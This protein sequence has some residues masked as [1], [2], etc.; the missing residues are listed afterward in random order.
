MPDNT[1]AI[2]DPVPAVPATASAAP[3]PASAAPAPAAS[4]PPSSAPAPAVPAPASPTPAPAARPGGIR[5]STRTAS[6]CILLFILLCGAYI[7]WHS[8]A[9]RKYRPRGLRPTALGFQWWNS[10]GPANNYPRPG[11]RPEP[12]AGAGVGPASSTS[13]LLPN[14][15][16]FYHK[17]LIYSRM[18]SLGFISAYRPLRPSAYPRLGFDSPYLVP[19]EVD[20]SIIVPKS[21]PGFPSMRPALATVPTRPTEPTGS[22][23]LAQSRGQPPPVFQPQSSSQTLAQI[24]PLAQPPA[25]ATAQPP[26][27]ASPADEKSIFT[28]LSPDLASS[29]CLTGDG[30]FLLAA[31]EAGNKIRIWEVKTGKKVNEITTPA[32][33]HLFCTGGNVYVANY[34]SGTI[35]VYAQQTWEQVNQLLVS[36]ANPYYISAPQGKYFDD[37]LLVSCGMKDNFEVH[38]VDIKKDS[39]RVVHSGRYELI[40]TLGYAG[41]TVLLQYANLSPQIECLAYSQFLKGETSRKKSL[42]TDTPGLQLLQQSEDSPFWFNGL[43]TVYN[44][45]SVYYGRQPAALAFNLTGNLVPDRKGLLAYL[46]T[47]K[48]IEAMRID[49]AFAP[50]ARAEANIGWRILGA[51]AGDRQAGLGLPRSPSPGLGM[52]GTQGAKWAMPGGQRQ[53]VHHD[54]AVYLFQICDGRIFRAVFPE[55]LAKAEVRPRLRPPPAPVQVATAGAE[56]PAKTIGGQPLRLALAP[57]GGGPGKFTLVKGP[58]GASLSPDGTLS[59]TP[60]PQDSGPVHFK[61][62]AEADGQVSFLRL[63]TDVVPASLAAKVGNDASKLNQIGQ[64]PLA[65]ENVLLRPLGDGSGV[66]LLEGR[67]LRIL[68]PDGI[69]ELQSHTFDLPYRKVADRKNYFVALGNNAV[70]LLDRKTFKVLRHYPIPCRE[71]YDLVLHPQ[72]P[73]AYVTLADADLNQG[74]SSANN[75]IACLD[76]RTG[77]V[78]TMPRVFGQWLAISPNG[79]T[80]YSCLHRDVISGLGFNEQGGLSAVYNSQ[81]LLIAYDL[82]G[83]VAIERQTNENPGEFGK[84]LR[85]SPEGNQLSYIVRQRDGSQGIRNEIAVFDSQDLLHPLGFYKSRSRPTSLSFHPDLG[86]VAVSDTTQIRLYQREKGTIVTGALSIPDGTVARCNQIMFTPNGK[87]LL[88]DY[89]DRDNQHLLQAFPLAL[90]P[91]A[92]PPLPTARPAVSPEERAKRLASI[93]KPKP[94]ELADSKKANPQEL[95]ARRVSDLYNQA[96][97]VIKNDEGTG[98]GFF[99]SSTGYILTCAHVVPRQGRLKISYREPKSKGF[100]TKETAAMPVAVD[101]KL[102]L[103]ILKIDT[104]KVPVK[105]VQLADR[106]TVSN[107]EV[108]YAIGNPG[109][110]REILDYTITEGI[111]S[112]SARLL[113]GASYIQTTAAVNPGSSGCPLFDKSGNV[114]GVVVLKAR[115]DGTGF[116]VPSVRFMKFLDANTAR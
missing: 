112:N 116:A 48:G 100:T 35:S 110:G 33:R 56:L 78:E 26:P 85:V 11:T 40:A 97:V 10:R 36:N 1:P 8:F 99:I 76:E 38:L 9:P 32:P 46:L 102:D 37:T 6:A 111:V 47:P 79:E 90:A 54:Q 55:L 108:V 25:T 94:A 103:A 44:T 27:P 75:T 106:E 68:D 71:A 12:G 95:D 15:Y 92:K 70:D 66:L 14:Y 41:E 84:G 115:I 98:S 7:W 24:R 30:A 105:H 18:A 49:F 82:F 4:V 28:E 77:T 13:P 72:E 19:M 69:V 91:E 86:L 67:R 43:D 20:A 81:D 113:E 107:G 59:W 16:A 88:L 80:L 57:A 2:P 51:G 22:S 74:R 5:L 63:A 39:D 58:A 42:A 3:D 34:G 65:E 101:Y 23:A 52:S 50:V 87:S 114:I 93:A 45:H 89:F 29:I 109:L 21:S 60:G 96:V 53:A 64:L 17:S 73:L 61:V 31:D 62:R 104:G 83:T